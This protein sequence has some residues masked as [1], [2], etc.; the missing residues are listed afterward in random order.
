MKPT[1][2]RIPVFAAVLLATAVSAPAQDEVD[3]LLFEID[4]LSAVYNA[5]APFP[6]TEKDDQASFVYGDTKNTIRQYLYEGG[7]LREKWKSF[8]LEGTVK[9]IAGAKCSFL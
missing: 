1:L 4:V 7:R 2:L 9:Q 5:F 3:D 8:P 6:W